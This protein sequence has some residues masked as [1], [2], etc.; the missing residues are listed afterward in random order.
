MANTFAF[1]GGANLGEKII[2]GYYALVSAASG[3][4][5]YPK[6]ST[7]L[8]DS[9][10]DLEDALVS[11]VS[12]GKPTFNAAVSSGGSRCV[13]SLDSS[14]VYSISPIPSSYPV[15]ICY[16]V[17]IPLSY[18]NADDPYLIVEDVERIGVGGGAVDSVNSKVGAVSIVAG[19]NMVVD[20]S[21]ANIVLNATGSGTGNSYFPTGW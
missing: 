14:G 12:G 7:F 6:G 11:Q 19:T 16:R 1:L 9:Y 3:T 15:A 5:V 17:K 21:G 20:N 4:I 13:C 18:F 8:P 2:A 10:Q